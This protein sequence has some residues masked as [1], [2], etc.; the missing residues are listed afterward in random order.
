MILPIRGRLVLQRAPCGDMRPGLLRA[1]AGENHL[2]L[3][4]PKDIAEDIRDFS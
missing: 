1:L 3:M 2:F 4:L